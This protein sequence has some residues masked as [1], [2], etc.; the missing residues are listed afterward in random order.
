V[1]VG[2][3][4]IVGEEADIQIDFGTICKA[5]V[6]EIQEQGIM[7]V[8]RKGMRPIF[9]HNSSLN[10]RPVS[11]ASALGLKMGDVI[12]VQYQGRDQATGQHRVSRKSLQTAMPVARNMLK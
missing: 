12:T 11:H 3:C 7:V 1:I 10:A 4:R 8:L 9:M 6:V 5:E 2:V